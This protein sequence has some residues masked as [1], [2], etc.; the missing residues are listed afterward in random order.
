[1]LPAFF[2]LAL[3]PAASLCGINPLATIERG[4]ASTQ[5]LVERRQLRST[6]QL[7][8]FQ[9]PERLPNN[10]ACGVVAAR[11]YLGVDELL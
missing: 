2:R 5:F 11:L 1:M 8:F 3:K 9:K 6:S 4:Q 10:L 7:V